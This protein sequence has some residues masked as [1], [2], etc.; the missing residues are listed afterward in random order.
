MGSEADQ[1]PAGEVL[2]SMDGR[3]VESLVADIALDVRKTKCFGHSDR[4][5]IWADISSDVQLVNVLIK[6]LI[7]AKYM[8]ITEL[9]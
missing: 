1:P 9:Y 2:T 7:I 3:E 8:E 5:M 6:E 4:Q